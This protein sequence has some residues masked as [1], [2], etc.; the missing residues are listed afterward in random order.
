MASP[1]FRLSTLRL[2]TLDSGLS[3]LKPPDRLFIQVDVYLF[4]VQVLLDAPLPQLAAEA[5]LLVAAPRCFDVGRLHVV[6]PH[7]AGAQRLHRAQRSKDVAR[8]HGSRKSV[9]GVVRDT[10]RLLLVVERDD[11]RHGTKNLF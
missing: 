2:W 8:P 4:D 3:T 9:V 1:D 5:A 7:D 10:Q 11:A 6:D